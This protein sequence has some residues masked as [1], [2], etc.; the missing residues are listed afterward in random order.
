MSLSLG[1]LQTGVVSV[2]AVTHFYLT[3][4]GNRKS[5]GRCFMCLDFSH[6]YNLLFLFS[7]FKIIKCDSLAVG[8]IMNCALRNLRTNLFELERRDHHAHDTTVQNGVLIHVAHFTANVAESLHDLLTDGNVAHFTSLESHHHSHL[9]TA[10]QK[11]HGMARLGIE[12][13]GIDPTGQLNFLQLNDLLLLLCFLFLF[14]SLKAIFSVVHNATYGGLCLRRHQNQIQT[15]VVRDLQ[16]RIGAHN[17]DGIS[18]FTDHA[19]LFRFDLLIDQQFFCANVKYTS[20]FARRQ[21]KSCEETHSA[22]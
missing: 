5:L 12:I 21:K 17:S 9:I 19:N 3:G 7:D 16:C 15:V 10:L 14:V 20:D 1:G 4:S 11:L 13:V 22:R 18:V 2:M 8:N 6:V